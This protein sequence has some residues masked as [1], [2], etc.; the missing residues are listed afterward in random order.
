M[1]RRNDFVHANGIL[2]FLKIGWA[3]NWDTSYYR[4]T[5]I[6]LIILNYVRR[7]TKFLLYA[8]ID[9]F[10]KMCKIIDGIETRPVI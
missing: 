2:S 3:N 9:F 8:E 6:I 7:E 1:D 5:K 4:I 10:S